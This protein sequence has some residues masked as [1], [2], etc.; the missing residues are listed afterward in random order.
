MSLQ[1]R[2]FCVTATRAEDA[3]PRSQALPGNAFR[4]APPRLWRAEMR[5]A[6]SYTARCIVDYPQSDGPAFLLKQ[7]QFFKRRHKDQQ[8]CQVW[9]EGIYPKLICDERMLRQS[10]EYA[11]Y[12][13]EKRGYVDRS[14][15]WRYSSAR[16]YAGNEGLVVID[17]LL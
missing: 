2:F 9:Q 3:L 8:T 4:E 14:E 1:Y 7:L 5:K 13:P 6:K 12:N 11:H 16:D 10:M 15:H 17:R